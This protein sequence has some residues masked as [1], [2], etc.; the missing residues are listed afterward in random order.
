VTADSGSDLSRIWCKS[1]Q[2]FPV[3]PCL[4]RQRWEID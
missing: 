2:G 4:S 1:R 3:R